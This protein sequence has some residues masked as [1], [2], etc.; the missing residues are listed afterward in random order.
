MIVWVNGPFGVG[1]TT[2]TKLLVERMPN[3]HVFD[4]E[5]IGY[6]LRPT[7]AA[8][9]PV[10]DFQD[11]RPWRILSV[12]AIVEV[13][14]YLDGD[15]IVPQTVLVRNYWTELLDGLRERGQLVRAFTL[16]VTPDEHERRIAT[17]VVDAAAAEWRR[18]RA[19]DFHA[20]RE[21]LCRTSTVIDTTTLSPSQVADDILARL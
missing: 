14:E 16:D 1:K 18:N 2:V 21:W 12:A 9:R 3:A 13:A 4:T 7:L 19:P 20:A 6:A 8:A 11:W 5:E 10:E 17:D 15:I